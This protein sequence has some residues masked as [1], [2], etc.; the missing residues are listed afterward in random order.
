[1][2]GADTTQILFL[3]IA[4]SE[5]DHG[6]VDIGFASHDGTYCIDFAVHTISLPP[7]ADDG[8]HVSSEGHPQASSEAADPIADFVLGTID[9]YR[10]EHFY[11]FAGAGIS[12]TAHALSPL[13]A[14]RL[15]AELDIV[16]MVLEHG[17]ESLRAG[18]PLTVDEEAD[19][20]ARKCLS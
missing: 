18:Q 7:L 5:P 11:K 17:P 1:M 13:L 9:E 2:I 8:S 3:G 12:T 20:M 16:P 15:W 14:S 19:S 10:K 6:Q 4:V